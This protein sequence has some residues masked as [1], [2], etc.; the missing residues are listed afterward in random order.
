MNV[1]WR[2]AAAAA[3]AAAPAMARAPPQKAS[4][5]AVVDE[6]G[7][8]AILLITGMPSSTVIDGEQKVLR[9]IFVG[10]KVPFIEVDGLDVAMQKQRNALFA[11]SGLRGKYPQVFLRVSGVTTFV[12]DFE[13]ASSLNDCDDIPA[14]VLAHN[15]NIE[16]LSTTFAQLMR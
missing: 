7:D 10:K 2:P 1:F 13:K 5:P 16:T 12:G 4:A 6:G 9:N 3:A 11:V 15:P 8:C 14:D